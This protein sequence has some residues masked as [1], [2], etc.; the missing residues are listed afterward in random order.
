MRDRGSRHSYDAIV[1]EGR[2]PSTPESVRPKVGLLPAE[3]EA[4]SGPESVWPTKEARHRR[5][6]SAG[7]V[8]G[9]M[10]RQNRLSRSGPKR[11]DWRSRAGVFRLPERMS[12]HFR[13]TRRRWVGILPNRGCV[14]GRKGGQGDITRS[15]FRTAG[16]P[17]VLPSGA[18]RFYSHQQKERAEFGIFSLVAENVERTR[19]SG[20]G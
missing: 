18:Q 15:M 13:S 3:W 7:F 5:E 1:E 19:W 12:S 6:V 14:C 4:A 10:Q 17:A 20:I 11:T 9:A 8:G 16:P 2:G